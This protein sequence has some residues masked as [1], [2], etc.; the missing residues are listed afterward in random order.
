[1]QDDRRKVREGLA[2]LR[3]TD[4]PARR[5][6]A[7][8]RPRT[9]KPSLFVRAKDNQSQV[10]RGPSIITYASGFSTTP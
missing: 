4:E 2:K 5:D 8:R 9:D 3:Q 10:L 7:Q 1:M 6:P